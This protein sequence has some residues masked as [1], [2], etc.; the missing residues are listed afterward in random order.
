MLDAARQVMVVADSSKLGTVAFARICPITS[1]DILV[2]DSAADQRIL[3]LLT[4][5]GVRVITT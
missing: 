2:T 4:D 5:R 1:V 3:E